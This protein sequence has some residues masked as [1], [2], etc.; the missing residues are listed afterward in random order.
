MNNTHFDN[1]ELVEDIFEGLGDV[2][3][4][5]CAELGWTALRNAVPDREVEEEEKS[6]EDAEM[7]QIDSASPS[8][9]LANMLSALTIAIPQN[10][11]LP[12]VEE[13]D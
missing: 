7:E 8:V 10:Q 1:Y 11:I 6:N 9:T 2:I 4:K 12:V 13:T 5:Q 3:A